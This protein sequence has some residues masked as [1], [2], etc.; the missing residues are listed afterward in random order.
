MKHDRALHRASR[1]AASQSGYAAASRELVE[2]RV[3]R[4]LPLVRRAAW[5]VYG[6]GRPEF[7]GMLDIEDLVQCGIVALTECAQKHSGPGEDGFA[8]YAK[9]R[10]RGAMLDQIRRLM[11]DTRGARKKR[12]AYHHVL[13]RLRAEQG[14]EPTR[15]QIAQALGIS[16]GELREIEASAI[17][18][19]SIT[20]EYDEASTAFAS[21]DPDPFET[22]SQIEDR[23]RL[24]TAM[25][26]LPER[27]TL[28][29]QLFY[30]EE[31]NLTEIAAVLEVSVPRVHQL[32]AK[33]LGD[34]KKLM[35]ISGA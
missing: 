16:D 6:M 3:R 14:G 31:L 12:A 27:L 30:V 18:L 8:A 21:D 29:L 5:H 32:R 20:D 22:L 33:A 13:D 19:T 26:R 10:V 4:F 9:I 28:V 2:D 7:A 17:T 1:K 24:I 34:L 25:Q 11:H 23:D 15:A 35:E